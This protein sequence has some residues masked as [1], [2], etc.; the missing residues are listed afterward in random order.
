MAI[1]TKYSFRIDTPNPDH[2]LDTR[3]RK[4]HDYHHELWSNKPLPSKRLFVINKSKSAPFYFFDID[5]VTKYSSD[6]IFQ[7]FKSFKILK[8]IT[9]PNLKLINE[10][11][12]SI[13]TT[14]GAYIIFPSN[15]IS[16]KQTINAARGYKYKWLIGDRFDLTIECIRRFYLDKENKTINPLMET[17]LLYKKFF[18]LFESFEGYIKFFMLEDLVQKD[19]NYNVNFFMNFK[20]FGEESVFP[21]D[22]G[23]FLRYLSNMET[24]V[25]KRNQRIEQYINKKLNHTIF[26]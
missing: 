11:I 8:K 14:I 22:E 19:N 23:E 21:K 2:D 20:E 17:L 1:D 12:L 24:F 4:L 13:G 25:Y 26:L 5:N 6:S 3:S 10:K 15:R 18:D 16:Y 7:S 9:E